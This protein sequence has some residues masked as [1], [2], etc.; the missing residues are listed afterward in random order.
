MGSQAYYVG[1]A[2]AVRGSSLYWWADWNVGNPVS[3][4]IPG[5]GTA[6]ELGVPL[7]SG[8]TMSTGVTNALYP[9]SDWVYLA[10]SNVTPPAIYRGSALGG[11]LSL[12]VSLFDSN[13]AWPPGHNGTLSSG[14]IAVDATNVYWGGFGDLLGPTVFCVAR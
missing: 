2:V 13:G 11:P 9:Q 12:V 3:L 8:M 7:A 4:M 1:G 5:G 10:V 6:I 14:R